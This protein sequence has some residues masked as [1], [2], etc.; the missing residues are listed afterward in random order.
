MKYAESDVTWYMQHEYK[1]GYEEAS[2]MK[3][4]I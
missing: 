1:L 3:I 2:A 4:E